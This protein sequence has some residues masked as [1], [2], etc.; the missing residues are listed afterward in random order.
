MTMSNIQAP[1]YRLGVDVGGTFTDLLLINES[2]GET[3]PGKVP[4]TPADSSIGVL[5]GIASLCERH[6]IDPK[7][8]THVMHGTTVATNTV[9]TGRAL[10]SA[11]SPP[12]AT[13]RCCRSHGPS[14]PAASAAG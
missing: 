11:S 4:S 7:R 3:Y 5:N 13:A 14:C 12:R 6:A 2:T 8:I 1:V 9:L 10:A